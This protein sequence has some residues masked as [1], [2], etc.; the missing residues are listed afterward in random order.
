MFFCLLLPLCG[1]VYD[2]GV[3]SCHEMKQNSKQIFSSKFEPNVAVEFH[4]A[5]VAQLSELFESSVKI[6]GE[7]RLCVG[8]LADVKQ[9][10]FKFKIMQALFEPEFYAKTLPDSDEYEKNIEKYRAKLRYFSSQSLDNFILVSSFNKAYNNALNPL[11]DYFQSRLID[12][13]SA[14]YYAVK[15]LNEFVKFSSENLVDLDI[16]EFE[17]SVSDPKIGEFEIS[18]LVFTTP[19]SKAILQASFKTA[20]LYEKDTQTLNEFIKLGVDINSGYEN[21][22]FFA[23]KNLQNVKFL[24]SLGADVNYANALEMT[25]LFKAVGL[26]NLNLVKLLVENGADVN[27]KLINL[28]TKLAYSSNLNGTLPNFVK[29]CDFEATSRTILMQAA[30]VAD[31]E[32]LEYLIE[33][34]AD[35]NAID[36]M[37]L[38]AL[39]HAII[40]KK[41][42]NAQYLKTLGLTTNLQKE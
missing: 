31:V 34:N 14:I 17:K 13:G 5:Q 22:L 3:L 32:I 33:N 12:S 4:C 21:S 6:H 18:Q 23:L 26:N 36:D 30:R 37:G 38:N 24:I 19:F 40:S 2:D 41:E 29:L 39:D 42:I 28:N 15:L 9:N 11:V 1:S 8:N 16:S 35:I 7:S 27:H 20:L 25:P 10:E